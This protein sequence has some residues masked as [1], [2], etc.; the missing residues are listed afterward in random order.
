[1]GCSRSALS[2]D[3]DE[4]DDFK[5]LADLNNVGWDV[6]SVYATYAKLGYNTHRLKGTMLVDFVMLL[7]RRDDL[8]K[9]YKA[10]QKER[11]FYAK[12]HLKY[13]NK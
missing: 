6:Y 12:L 2:D 4:W 7:A 3:I 8:E 10:E 11:E 1:M 9:S 5:V 13:G